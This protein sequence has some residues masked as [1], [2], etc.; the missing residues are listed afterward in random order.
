MRKFGIPRLD[1]KCKTMSVQKK[2]LTS[3]PKNAQQYPRGQNVPYVQKVLFSHL[4]KRASLR[5]EWI[6]H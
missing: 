6:Y 3:W 5:R 1:T 2:F 4:N